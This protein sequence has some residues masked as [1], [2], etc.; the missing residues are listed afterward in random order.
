MYMPRTLFSPINL[1]L[2]PYMMWSDDRCRDKAIWNLQGGGAAILD[3]VQPE[4]VSK[5]V[6]KTTLEVA[7]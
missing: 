2:E 4:V 5:Q 1:I 3:L 7:N 6:S